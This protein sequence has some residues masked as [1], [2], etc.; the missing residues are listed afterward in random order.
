MTNDLST[1]Q[2]FLI[3][4]AFVAK[5]ISNTNIASSDTVIDIGA[6][7]GVITNELSKKV[8]KVIAIELDRNLFLVLKNKFSNQ[9]NIK[10]INVDF[11][12]YDL[13]EFK[14]K[15]FAN[16]PFIISADIINKILKLPNE[17]DSAYLFLQDK[18]AER[19]IGGPNY[20]DSQVSILY[21]P[22]Y[23]MFILKKISKKEFRPA[24]SVDVVLCVF[25]KKTIP[26]LEIKHN[27]MYRDFVIYGFNQWKPTLLESFNKVFTNDQLKIISK[28]NNLDKLKPSE[29]DIKQWINLFNTFLNYVPEEKKLSIKGY[30]LKQIAKQKDMIKRHRTRATR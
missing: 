19:F 15:I 3:N 20:N 16:P 22:F 5:L 1:S 18:T 9:K 10:I 30:E 26:L 6:G 8:K 12:K 14:Y 27:Q 2:N 23:D 7:K 17:L 4:P 21:K 29:V 28:N 24:P 25:V 13:P 11:L